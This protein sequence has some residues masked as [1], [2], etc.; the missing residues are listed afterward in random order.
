MHTRATALSRGSARDASTPDVAHA[1]LW[2]PSG[3]RCTISSPAGN[4]GMPRVQRDAD[5]F[6]SRTFTPAR[7]SSIQSP[8]STLRQATPLQAAVALSW[9][10]MASAPLGICGNAPRGSVREPLLGHDVPFRAHGLAR[11]SAPSPFHDFSAPSGQPSPVARKRMVRQGCQCIAHI[12]DWM[13]PRRFAE[14]TATAAAAG[15]AARSACFRGPR[16]CGHRWGWP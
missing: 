1:D 12:R 16:Q 10:H 7:W 2:S 4:R 9:G 14:P 6:F 8:L 5:Y 15:C 3:S 13:G 11:D